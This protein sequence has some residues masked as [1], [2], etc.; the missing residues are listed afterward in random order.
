MAVF[1]KFH[2]ICTIFSHYLQS[3]NIYIYLDKFE[4]GISAIIS[5]VLV[6]SCFHLKR[7]CKKKKFMKVYAA[8]FNEYSRKMNNLYCFIDFRVR[9]VV[10]RVAGGAVVSSSGSGSSCSSCSVVVVVQVVIVVVLVVVI[11]VAVAQ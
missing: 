7:V 9:T 11:A 8:I 2:F 5:V 1:F 4:E 6:S 10:V 3:I